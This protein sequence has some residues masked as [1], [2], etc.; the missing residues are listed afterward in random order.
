[1]KVSVSVSQNK[2]SCV[3]THQILRALSRRAQ[4]RGSSIDAQQGLT[5]L[6]RSG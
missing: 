4:N 2:G 3:D 6:S 5:D 1:M